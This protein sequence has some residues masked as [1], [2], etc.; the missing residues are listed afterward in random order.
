MHSKVFSSWTLSTLVLFLLFIYQYN[1]WVNFDQWSN[2]RS[3][4]VI[5]RRDLLH[6]LYFM[7]WRKLST[8]IALCA[9]KKKKKITLNAT[10]SIDTFFISLKEEY[11]SSYTFIILSLAF[12]FLLS[13]M[14]SWLV[15]K[16]KIR[17]LNLFS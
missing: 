5:H 1:A 10:L 14:N 2:K 8:Y 11:L 12:H 9:R 13:E 16:N 6:I 15:S 3:A 7:P 4:Q 17:Y